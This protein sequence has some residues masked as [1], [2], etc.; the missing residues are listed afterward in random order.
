M[1]NPR[2]NWI[3]GQAQR[4]ME[5]ARRKAAANTPEV[6]M[7]QTPDWYQNRENL[8]RA[9]DVLQNMPAVTTD[10]GES[11]NMYQILMNQMKG[12]DKGARLV[13]KSGTTY[14]PFPKA[15]FG[16][17]FY[18]EQFPIASGLGSLMEGAEN[19]MP[20]LG[21][22]KRMFGREREP[23]ERDPRYGPDV[24][25]GLAPSADWESSIFDPIEDDIVT[26]LVEGETKD[27]L[28]EK[29]VNGEVADETKE[30]PFKYNIGEVLELLKSNEIEVNPEKA[31]QHGF[32]GS[33]TELWMQA[34]E[35]AKQS[36][37]DL[38]GE[39]VLRMLLRDGWFNPEDI[40][41]KY[42]IADFF[43]RP[44]DQAPMFTT[45]DLPLKERFPTIG[46]DPSVHENLDKIGFWDRSEI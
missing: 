12:G 19:F 1:A 45:A 28:V 8:S 38:S 36:G 40:K 31:A 42:N 43:P 6:M 14:N 37:L 32:E 18:K 13:D 23:L 4:S 22:A 35:Q 15:G 26:N 46:E 29:I 2:E 33:A 21:M 10:P 5:D 34:Q 24:L 39:E 7:S 9:K 20:V 30:I 17:K 41:D 25:K 16:S 44:R 27:D 11:R 3:A